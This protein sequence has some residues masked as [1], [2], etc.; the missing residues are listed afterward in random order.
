V[1]PTTGLSTF[2]TTA[3]GPETNPRVPWDNGVFSFMAT[4]RTGYVYFIDDYQNKLLTNTTLSSNSFLA[5]VSLDPVP[6]ISPLLM[7]GLALIGLVGFQTMRK[8]S[9]ATN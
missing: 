8:R 2:L 9:L 7:V 6:E 5:D 4:A 3:H 1:T